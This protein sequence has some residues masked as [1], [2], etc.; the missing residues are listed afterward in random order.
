MQSLDVR[1]HK[2]V[3]QLISEPGRLAPYI[4]S[5]TP[6]HFNLCPIAQYLAHELQIN[7][8]SVYVREK[9]IFVGEIHCITPQFI[10]D[11]LDSYDSRAIRRGIF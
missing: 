5:A 11:F 7:V 1:L 9:Q 6:L 4:L 2:A 8:N 10:S 3:Q